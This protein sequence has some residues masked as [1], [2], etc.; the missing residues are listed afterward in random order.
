[1]TTTDRDSWAVSYL[2]ANRRALRLHDELE[3][4]RADALRWQRRFTAA[5]YVL[6]AAVGVIIGLGVSL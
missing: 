3:G 5:V 4:A 2:E 1:M 6:A